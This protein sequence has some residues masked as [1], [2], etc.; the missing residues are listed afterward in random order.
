MTL[1]T[2]RSFG[3]PPDWVVPQRKL[4]IALA[5]DAR[6]PIVKRVEA[7]QLLGVLG[8]QSCADA[9]LVL[10]RS[11][12]PKALTLAV[13]DALGRF[14]DEQ[15]CTALLEQ[16]SATEPAVRTKTGD[17]L[18]SRPSSALRLLN[19]VDH[20]QLAAKELSV[21]Q[22][23]LVALHHD[24]RLD[25]LVKKYWGSIQGGTPED[26]LAEMRRINNDLRAGRGELAAGHALFTKHCA[27]CHRLFNE[28]NQIGPELT[29]ANRKNSD[30]LLSTI[31]S[32]SAV[33]RKEYLSFLVQ[34]TDGR[35]LSGLLV[36]QSP[37]SVTL[38]SAKN[39]RTTVPRDKIEAI[40]ESP[41]SLM[42]EN[43][44]SPLKPQEL[45]DLFRYLQ[46]DLPDSAVR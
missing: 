12:Q 22:L 21:D 8:Q 6:L 25:A 27:T 14:D 32:P 38:L 24:A 10:L 9:L 37:S 33:I 16:L 46:S 40:S 34:T 3:S 23:R 15:I 20:G 26:R 45:R 17:V 39:E 31:V 41:T 18:L 2:S 36:E 30:E 35:V 4:A 29:H 11:S 1:S 28:G 43:L 19:A 5:T 7:V 13:V 44:L 42:P